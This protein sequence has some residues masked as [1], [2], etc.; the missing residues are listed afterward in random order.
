[1]VT[2]ERKN[3]LNRIS[4]QR[5]KERKAKEEEEAAKAVAKLQHKKD[6]KKGQIDVE[7]V[8]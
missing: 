1:M 7:C 2:K 6:L 3:E 5:V 8:C 4:R